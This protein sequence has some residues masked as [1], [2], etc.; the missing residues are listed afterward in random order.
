M[1]NSSVRK[2]LKSLCLTVALTSPFIQG[3]A[4][5]IG[6]KVKDSGAKS[7]SVETRMTKGSLKVTANDTTGRYRTDQV[8]FTGY[9]KPQNS[10][11]ESFFIINNTDRTLKGV[12][13][14][15]NYN[16]PDGRQLHNRTEKIPCDIPAGETRKVDIS[17]WD[18]QHSFR[19][20]DSKGRP[21]ANIFTVTFSPYII[22]LRY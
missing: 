20:T 8:V 2:F 16:T 10:A 5:K 11:K 13:L 22:Y 3:E 9:D 21:E 7:E 19:Y 6:Y 1:K 4:R 12:I 15:I 18:T 17:S 14:N